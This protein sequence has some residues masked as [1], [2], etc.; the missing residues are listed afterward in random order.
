[1][2]K[3]L[4]KPW[5]LWDKLPNNWLAGFRPSTVLVFLMVKPGLLGVKMDSACGFFSHFFPPRKMV[6]H[7]I[8]GHDRDPNWK[9]GHQVAFSVTELG[10][11]KGRT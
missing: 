3:T 7:R 4:L 6:Y 5:R 11:P 8:V 1:M 9:T 2:Y 10:E